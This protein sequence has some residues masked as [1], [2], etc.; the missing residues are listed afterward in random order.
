MEDPFTVLPR[1]FDASL[2]KAVYSGA[3][4]A[5]GSTV[6]ARFTPSPI[7]LEREV[8]RHGDNGLL[9]DFFDSSLIARQLLD[10]LARPESY[11]PL[12]ARA[13]QTAGAYSIERGIAG[14][15][16]CLGVGPGHMQLPAESSLSEGGRD[17]V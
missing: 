17:D 10:V 15:L 13:A 11:R 16:E 8:I 5:V 7:K 6:R 14:Y 12:R 9:V 2:A 3:S 1:G 4:T